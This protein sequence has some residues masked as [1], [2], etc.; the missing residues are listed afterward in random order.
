[1]GSRSLGTLTIDLIAQIAGFVAGMDQAS[2]VAEE[3]SKRIEASIKSAAHGIEAAFAAFGVYEMITTVGD[4]TAQQ[5]QA[6]ARLQQTLTSTGNTTG[7]T[8]EE[9]VKLSKA[10]SETTTFTDEMVLSAA[11][12]LAGFKDIKGDQFEPMLRLVT[13]LATKTGNLEEAAKLLG[14]A[15][16]DPV[17]SMRTFREQG[18]IF[19]QTTQDMIQ[20]YAQLGD[21]AKAAAIIV[22]E[23]N[24]RVGGQAGVQANTLG[25]ALTQL[26]NA[27]NDLFKTQQ[28]V[29]QVTDAVKGL[30]EFLRDPR[31]IEAAEGFTSAIINGFAEAGRALR[32][33][34]EITGNTLSSQFDKEI[35]RRKAQIDS[36]EKKLEQ[37]TA[38][39]DD[40]SLL[41]RLFGASKEE[42]D[43]QIAETTAQLTEA[44]KQLEIYQAAVDKFRRGEQF[45]V[46]TIPKPIPD[47]TLPAS[48][49]RIPL[50]SELPSTK[51]FEDA[52]RP[53]K[54]QIALFGQVGEAAKIAYEIQ[55]NDSDRMRKM[56]EGEKQSLL[57]LAKQVDALAH[58]KAFSDQALQYAEQIKL[59]EMTSRAEK[60]RF[61]TE[62]G[63]LKTLEPAQKQ[64]LIVWAQ[65]ADAI[66]ETVRQFERLQQTQARLD[67]TP[68]ERYRAALIDIANLPNLSDATR[69]ALTT[70]QL[71]TYEASTKAI[72]EQARAMKASIDPLEQY[73]QNLVE[74]AKL[75]TVVD[76]SGKPIISDAEY[77]RWLKQQ[78]HALA[79]A[80][81]L[82]TA[83]RDQ[84]QRNMQD[85]LASWIENFGKTK[86]S[87]L[88]GFGD[89]LKKLAAQAAAAKI[90]KQVFDWADAAG[91]QG[92]FI[93][94][95]GDIFKSF[96]GGP[97]PAVPVGHQAGGPFQ[98][99]QLIRVGEGGPEDIVAGFNGYVVPNMGSAPAAG[100]LTVQVI[101]PPSPPTV[102]ETTDINGRR[103]LQIMFEQMLGQ[104]LADGRV[105]GALRGRYGLRPMPGGAR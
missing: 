39:R 43:K 60:A 72:N 7:K 71:Q 50:Q 74:M 22:D 84:A 54:E 64:Q 53:L 21:R 35:D 73:R 32:W 89:M 12:V 81:D 93:G 38:N 13:D 5:E 78:Q 103:Q 63:G 92:G 25:G 37:Q 58:M 36:L 3:R 61:D 1:M 40:K 47:I 102:A 34:A 80:T 67:L 44:K 49:V 94:K 20:R 75:R 68:L 98:A 101:N 18:I 90:M 28:G 14:R 77:N 19:D 99:G 100:G 30:T 27:W 8:T 105:D 51:E 95:L 82:W 46:G 62:Y 55:A 66:E 42:W 10:I 86:D 41:H 11:N 16:E 29:Q 69:S 23:L 65:T 57:D 85:A 56:R 104:S 4:A 48:A 52:A 33:F 24:K 6:V 2:R 97:V 59:I 45:G 87:I 96:F 91:G 26:S 88:A 9:I 15:I 83:F 70:Q 79:Q 31:T 17:K 76:D